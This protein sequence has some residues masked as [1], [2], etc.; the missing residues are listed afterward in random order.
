MFHPD[1]VRLLDALKKLSVVFDRA[2]P[3]RS[4]RLSANTEMALHEA[5]HLTSLE[6]EPTVTQRG[7]LNASHH[8]HQAIAWLPDARAHANEIQV[9]AAEVLLLHYL[10]AFRDGELP[11]IKDVARE[12]SRILNFVSRVQRAKHQDAT[13]ELAFKTVDNVFKWAPLVSR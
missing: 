2:L 11:F 3:Y 9:I 1:H 5:L 6:L 13:K 4:L 7:M 8:I 12:Q 10:H